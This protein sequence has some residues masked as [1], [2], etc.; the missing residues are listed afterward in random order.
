MIIFIKALYYSELDPLSLKWQ[1]G[2]TPNPI[3]ASRLQIT[4]LFV[5][6]WKVWHA[7]MLWGRIH[8][9]NTSSA[10]SKLNK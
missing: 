2:K 3:L 10:D 8:S 7:W 1:T 4:E 9:P 6:Q 5:D